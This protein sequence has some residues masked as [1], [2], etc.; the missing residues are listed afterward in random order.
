MTET[1]ENSPSVEPGFPHERLVSPRARLKVL[2]DHRQCGG[3]GCKACKHTGTQKVFP[4]RPIFTMPEDDAEFER[5]RL[6]CDCPCYEGITMNEGVTQCSHADS[7]S[8][9]CSSD[10][11]PL[12]RANGVLSGAR[13][14]RDGA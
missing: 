14:G 6:N 7:K 13:T 1:T 3:S 8:D 11:C 2:I 10:V 4:T 9:W 5:A 12:P